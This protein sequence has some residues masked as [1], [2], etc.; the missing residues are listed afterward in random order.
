GLR[1]VSWLRKAI[2]LASGRGWHIR[3]PPV[4]KW[5]RAAG[6]DLA[7]GQADSS[8]GLRLGPRA[9]TADAPALD[10]ARQPGLQP[11]LGSGL[12]LRLPWSPGRGGGVDRRIGLSD[13]RCAQPA[14]T[15]PAPGARPGTGP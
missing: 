1:S 11:A 3:S 13:H 9:A 7:R 15:K 8:R 6:R 2:G 4:R 5:W 14:R 12:Y 10:R